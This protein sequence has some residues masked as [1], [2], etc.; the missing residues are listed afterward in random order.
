MLTQSINTSVIG[1]KNQPGFRPP[2]DHLCAIT[3]HAGLVATQ[4]SY[5][6]DEE[7]YGEDD[8]PSMY[9]RS[10]SAQFGI[11]GCVPTV[12]VK[13]AHSTFPATRSA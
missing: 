2:A 11:A 7:I 9:I 8:L 6:K 4:F 3:G 13:S 10:L 1:N 5:K 12:R